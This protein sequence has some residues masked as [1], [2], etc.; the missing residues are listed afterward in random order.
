[1]KSFT[2]RHANNAET[3]SGYLLLETM[4]TIGILAVGLLGIS[5][6][7]LTS[8]KSGHSAVQRGEAA[9]LVAA[10]TDRMRA[11]T[12]GVYANNYHNLTRSSVMQT[13][14]ISNAQERAQFDYDVWR[15]EIDRLFTTST[16]PTG[17]I[18]CL[19]T[20]NCVL[21]IGWEDNRANSALQNEFLNL[22]DNNATNDKTAPKYKH[23][24]SVVF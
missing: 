6:M 1:M 2:V 20:T 23:V 24:V 5:A 13:G 3:Q 17:T 18:N 7:Q 10:M 11:N 4:I 16:S 14:E 9:F 8:L 21:E 15:N 19:T 22:N 12:Y